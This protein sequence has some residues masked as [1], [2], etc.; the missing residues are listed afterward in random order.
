MFIQLTIGVLLLSLV[1]GYGSLLQVAIGF[2]AI[3]VYFYPLIRAYFLAQQLPK[4][5]EQAFGK[6]TNT[7]TKPLDL[8][9]LLTKI[10][11][12]ERRSLTYAELDG[13]T[14]KLDYYNSAVSGKRPCVVV[15]HGGSWVS[16]DSRQLSSLNN[17]LAQI[18]YNVASI[19]YRLA[20][21]WNFPAPIEDATAALK[22]LR[23]HAD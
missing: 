8:T 12:I 18:G 5:L 11:R 6:W 23:A 13:I 15:I 21:K 10:Q 16:G 7:K 1:T 9:K 3:V 17:R 14:L 19:N 2:S 22:Y 20:P 4:D